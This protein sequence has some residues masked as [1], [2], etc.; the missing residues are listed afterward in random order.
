MP[1]GKKSRSV[2]ETDRQTDDRQAETGRQA[3]YSIFHVKSSTMSVFQIAT[4][5]FTSSSVYQ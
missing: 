1:L 3:G 4:F 2:T 5:L